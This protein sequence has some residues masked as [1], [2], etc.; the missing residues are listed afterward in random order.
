[1]S[2][3]N[4]TLDQ[5][6]NAAEYDAEVIANATSWTAFQKRGR[7]N[8]AKAATETREGAREAARGFLRDCPNPVL[9]YAVNSFGRQAHAETVSL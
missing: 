5:P 2:I 8:R 1:M 7:G 3:F 4:H 6:D 9:I